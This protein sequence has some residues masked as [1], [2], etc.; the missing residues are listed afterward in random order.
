MGWGPSNPSYQPI[1]WNFFLALG[2]KLSPQID[3]TL[4][5]QKE[6]GGRLDPQ[7]RT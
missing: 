5:T 7:S 3:K 6:K 4:S 2:F 1:G